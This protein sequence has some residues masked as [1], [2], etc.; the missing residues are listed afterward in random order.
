MGKTI[1]VDTLK[2]EEEGIIAE[3]HTSDISYEDFAAKKL[4]CW[5]VKKCGREPGGVKVKE[6]GVCPASELMPR[7]P[8]TMLTDLRNL[9]FTASLPA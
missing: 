8:T 6:L 4:N 7:K 1:P 2:P 9:P 5:E 3:L